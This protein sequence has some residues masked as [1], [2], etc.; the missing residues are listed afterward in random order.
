VAEAARAFGR[1]RLAERLET[2]AATAIHARPEVATAYAP[3]TDDLERQVAAVWELVL[4]IERVGIHDNFF[5]LGGTSLS[6]IQ[7][8]TEL[9]KQLGVDVPTVSIFQA[10]TVSALVR[11]LMPPQRTASEFERSRSRAEK[12]KQV[13]ARARRTAV[14]RRA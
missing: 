14:Q 11:Y 7:L 2:P 1:E 8:V 13:F 9:K 6:G 5:E 4:G 3:P 10:P 12:K